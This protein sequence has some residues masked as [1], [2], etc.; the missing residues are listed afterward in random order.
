ML[1]KP[2]HEYALGVEIAVKAREPKSGAIDADTRKRD[3]SAPR[4]EHFKIQIGRELIEHDRFVGHDNVVIHWIPPS[5]AIFKASATPSSSQ[6][7]TTVAIFLSSSCAFITAN[8]P[9]AS[10]SIGRSLS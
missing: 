3:R 8:F 1:C 2:D 5:C 6:E 9:P 10:L 7:L 4:I